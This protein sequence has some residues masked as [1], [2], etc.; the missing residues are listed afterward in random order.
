MSSFKAINTFKNIKFDNNIKPL[1]ICDIDHTVIKPKYNIQHYRN[2][3]ERNFINK[4]K[5]ESMAK[6]MFHM[7]LGVGLIQPTDLEGFNCLIK[8]I[9]NRN[10]RFIFLTARGE[11]SHNKTINDLFTIGISQPKKFKIHYTGGKISKGDYI[12]KHN[13]TNGFQHIYFIDDCPEY[14]LSATN[15]YPHM[16]CYLF[17]YDII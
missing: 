5:C 1:V 7:S 8:E 16:N 9:E 10:G 4:Y 11:S 12:K 3:L 14:L 6:S 2:K 17:K 13:L 15:I